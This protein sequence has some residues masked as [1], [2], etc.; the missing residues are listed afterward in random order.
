MPFWWRRR[1][2]N[3]IPRRQYIRYHKRR[4]YR[5]R[6]RFPRR[7]R[8]T[9]RR[10]RRRR[11]RKVRRK[12]KTIP[13]RQWQP[14][15]IVKCK[16]K[17]TGTLVLGAN[18]RQFVCYTNVKKQLTP[19]RAPCG[20]GFGYEQYSLEYL[21][22]EYQFRNNIWTKSNINKDLCRYLGVRM[23][24]YRH[25][26][27]DFILAYDRQPPFTAN[28]YTYAQCHPQQMLLGRHKKIILSKLT[29]PYGKTKKTIRI[30]PPKQ[31]ITKWFFQK[32]FSNYPLLSLRAAA[33]NFNYPHLSSS[34]SNQILTFFYINTQFYQLGNWGFHYTTTGSYLPYASVPSILYFWAQEPTGNTLTN[35]SN[36]P[37]QE[38]NKYRL[39]YNRPS[40]YEQSINHD[41]G[42]FQ[43]KILQ[44]IRITNNDNWA[45]WT[46]NIPANS[47]R[48]NPTV[49]QGPGNEIWLHSTLTADYNKPVRDP[50]LILKDQPLWL[51]LYG[52]LS[53]LQMLKKDQ[54]FF[55][56]YVLVMKSKALYLSGQTGASEYIIPI[57]LE[58]TQGKWPSDE[59][60]THFEHQHWY[61]TIY[62]QIN[63][64]NQIVCCGP[65][66]PKFDIG[67][68][69]TTWELNY[70]YQFFFKWGGPEIT[71]NLVTDPQLQGTYDV[72]DKFTGS[73]QIRDP[74][75]QKYET[76]LHPWDYRR[77]LIKESALKRMS[78]NLSIDTT[79][80]ADG[81]T[82]IKK[83]KVT[84]PELS[85]PQQENQEMLQCLRSLW[86]ESTSEEAQEASLQQ[87]IQ[88][89][90]QKQRDLKYNLL[91]ILSELKEQQLSLQL[92]TGMLP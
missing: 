82:P 90:Q 12:R 87:L 46:A 7:S 70:F 62:H 57:D 76:L 16:I 26:S 55:A 75:K 1:R 19:P 83:K 35:W 42:W 52:W 53:Y 60:V 22:R 17:G 10:K 9:F 24:F 33:A 88:Q 37:D 61:P 15:S 91:K 36:L 64:I 48:Y 58:F 85:V 65:Y 23:T 20:G 51:M 78:D 31:L 25:Q 86:E 72:P 81:E 2:K 63:I 71:D 77:G 41:T 4:N 8:K 67:Q 18:G 80:Q 6:R 28:E 40:T 21:Y 43:P 11:R 14:D 5:R 47:V 50:T 56:S 39:K 27:I 66:V 34:N 69:H 45:A 44:A 30:R 74:A 3:W 29:K 38:K 89:Q 73:V 84:G 32:Q 59:P 13:I 92:Q 79:F 54:N 49:D 68:R